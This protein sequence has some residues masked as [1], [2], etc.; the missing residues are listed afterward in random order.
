MAP[1]QQLADTPADTQSTALLAA[2]R[3]G[4]NAAWTMLVDRFDKKLRAVARSYRLS[5]Q[6]VDDVVQSAWVKLY[7]HVDSIRDAEA[8]GGWLATTVRRESLRVLQFGVRERLSDT[9][10]LD[11][12]DDGG[13]PDSRLLERERSVALS[14]ALQTL[15][16]RQR[17]LMTLIAHEDDANY[18]EIGAALDMPI[19]SIGPIRA[20]GLARLQHHPELLAVAG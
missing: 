12:A 15:P 5:S 11:R 19:G 13:G 6:D 14:R 3:T 2:A 4:D 18:R 1:Q 10:E 17:Q 7:E 16:D 9:L 20:R 8:V